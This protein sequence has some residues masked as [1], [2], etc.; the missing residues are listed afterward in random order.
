MKEGKG[1]VQRRIAEDVH[2]SVYMPTFL[3]FSLPTGQ[4]RWSLANSIWRARM[5]EDTAQHAAEAADVER[6]P[7]DEE[8]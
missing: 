3:L 5:R 2:D 4:T 1:F 6:T 8:V 7:S